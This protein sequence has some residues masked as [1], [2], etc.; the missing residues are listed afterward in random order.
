MGYLQTKVTHTC[1]R[2][3]T[4]RNDLPQAWH[5]DRAQSDADHG[6]IVRIVPGNGKTVSKSIVSGNPSLAWK[7]FSRQ[8]L[9]GRAYQFPPSQQQTDTRSSALTPQHGS[10]HGSQ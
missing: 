8:H 6:E 1:R 4:H 10:T 7:S 5:E 3:S 9:A 2:F